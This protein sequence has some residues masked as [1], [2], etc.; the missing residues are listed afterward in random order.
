MQLCPQ[1]L[2]KVADK[3]ANELAKCVPKKGKRGKKGVTLNEPRREELE[4][5]YDTALD[6]LLGD[7][8]GEST[9]MSEDAGP[10]SRSSTLHD[11]MS[12]N[13]GGRGKSNS[14][15]GMTGHKVSEA[16]GGR[17][18][19]AGGSNGAQGSE[20]G[21]QGGDQPV[22]KGGRRKN[23]AGGDGGA[24]NDN[25]YDDEDGEDEGDGDAGAGGA[26]MRRK[27]KGKRG[28]AGGGGAAGDEPADGDG[29]EEDG[30]DEMDEALLAELQRSPLMG[31]K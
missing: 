21:E 5:A 26:S 10:L 18:L 17:T 15:S 4:E 12:V 31:A 22:Q 9:L 30:S 3:K 25:D 1:Q 8:D 20:D 27:G 2:L 24:G 19:G 11:R 13:G 28:A 29:D 23:A 16:G 6:Q 7:D 14:G